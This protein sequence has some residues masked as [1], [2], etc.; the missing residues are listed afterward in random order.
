MISGDRPIL[1]SLFEL[2]T[3]SALTAASL[4]VQWL[5]RTKGRLMTLAAG[6][7]L[8]VPP[9]PAERRDMENTHLA[10]LRIAHVIAAAPSDGC[11]KE[12]VSANSQNGVAVAL[13][14]AAP[15]P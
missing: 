11:V 5:T 3:K 14:R 15:G 10:W 6:F 13:A 1:A 4:R 8:A 2:A 9:S 12:L 7:A